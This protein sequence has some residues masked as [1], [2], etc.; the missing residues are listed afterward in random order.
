MT[1]KPANRNSYEKTRLEEISGSR[2]SRV[3]G[4]LARVAAEVDWESVILVLAM[5]KGSPITTATGVCPFSRK[6]ALSIR[7]VIV[8]ARRHLDVDVDLQDGVSPAHR[9]RLCGDTS[10]RP[11]GIRCRD[12]FLLCAFASGFSL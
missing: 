4:P 3:L 12:V 5:T 6:I 7:G 9:D 11:T 10:R 1:G 8:C 2:S